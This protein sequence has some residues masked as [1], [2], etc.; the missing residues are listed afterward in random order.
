MI[1]ICQCGKR[2]PF[3]SFPS[4]DVC[5]TLSL[6]MRFG[7]RFRSRDIG[8]RD[9]VPRTYKRPDVQLLRKTFAL[10]RLGHHY[11]LSPTTMSY[12]KAPLPYILEDRTGLNNASDFDDI[13]DRIFFRIARPSPT[14]PV[15]MIYDMTRR[16]SRH[17]DAIPLQRDPLV[18]M[19]FQ[20]D[21]GLGTVSFKMIHAKP[22]ISVTIP[23][24]RWLTR[25]SMFGGSVR[26]TLAHSF[27]DPAPLSISSLS[28]K[29]LASDGKEYK[30]SHRSFA[31]HEWTVRCYHSFVIPCS[32]YSL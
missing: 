22:P 12:R 13:Y 16:A 18:V 7:I 25:T 6:D 21:D 26:T 8:Y 30:W 27:A 14:R 29:F 3:A 19:E 24:S 28:R 23:M 5:L 9:R 2:Y 4:V 17:R 31:G 15:T 32:E 11:L 20:Q 1:K 10:L